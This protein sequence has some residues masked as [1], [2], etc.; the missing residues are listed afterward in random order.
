MFAVLVVALLLG[1]PLLLSVVLSLLVL[2]IPRMAWSRMRASRQHRLT[3]QLPDAML[4]LAGRLRS[5]QGLTQ[6]IAQLAE[7]QPAPITQ[8]FQLL[9]RKQRLGMPFDRAL[10]ELGARVPT[11][12]Y[13]LFATAIRVAR[14]LGGNLGETLER[15]AESMRRR[16]AMENK[17]RALTSQGLLQGWIVGLLPIL[18]FMA[19]LIMEPVVMRE[20]FLRPL[21]WCALSVIVLLELAG[22]FV[23]RRIVRIDV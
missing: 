13:A 12:D 19:L 7:H 16:L 11:A 18:L 17:I 6:A 2:L 8:E 9:T 21:G 14:E 15:L 20:M 10:S 23:I 1:A 4:L 5:G 3:H 22:F